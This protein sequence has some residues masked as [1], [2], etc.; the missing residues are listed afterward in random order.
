MSL[1]FLRRSFVN[2]LHWY[3]CKNYFYNSNESFDEKFVI[4]VIFLN[5]S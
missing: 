1:Y 5:I 2:Q 4:S 3:E